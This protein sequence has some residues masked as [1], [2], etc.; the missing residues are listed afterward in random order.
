MRR[1]TKELFDAVAGEGKYIRTHQKD[2]SSSV[3]DRINRESDAGDS[4]KVLPR[5]PERIVG[6]DSVGEP[7][8]PV[9]QKGRLNDSLSTNTV[10]HR[11][12]R[13]SS[14]LSRELE[15]DMSK[16]EFIKPTQQSSNRPGTQA[17]S[18]PGPATVDDQVDV[19]EFTTS[20]P[21]SESIEI[22]KGKESSIRRR[23]SKSSRRLSSAIRDDLTFDQAEVPSRLKSAASRKRASMVLPKISGTDRDN[24]SEGGGGSFP[25]P[26]INQGDG[27]LLKDQVSMR[28]RSM[29]L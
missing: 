8:S 6:S 15:Q 11:R 29:M 4:W 18:Q 22:P 16:S 2:E 26:D 1:P 14:I 28:R 21:S 5:Q 27:S 3:S 7:E 19:Y 23:Q 17:T 10:T 20:S 25:R 9:G 12:K 13:S 24:M